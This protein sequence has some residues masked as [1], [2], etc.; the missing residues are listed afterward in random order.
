MLFIITDF[1]SDSELEFSAI[2][3]FLRSD[4]EGRPLGLGSFITDQKGQK[5]ETDDPL[6]TRIEYSYISGRFARRLPAS[7]SSFLLR[8]VF[9]IVR[10]VLI[11]LFFL[12]F[13]FTLFLG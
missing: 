10:L 7:L 6:K 13:F 12:L 2:D 11:F 4:R 1:S 3:F 5:L 8:G 9:I